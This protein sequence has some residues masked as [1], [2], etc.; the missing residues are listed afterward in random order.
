MPAPYYRLRVKSLKFISAVDA[1]AQGPVANVALIKRARGGSSVEATC[2]VIKTDERLGL[3]FG[4][5]LASSLDGGKTPHVDLQN[6]AV[7]GDDDLIKVAAEFV[8]AGARSDVLH[9]ESHDGRVVFCMPL[10]KDVNAALGIKSDVHGLAI[11]MRPSPATFKRFLSKE[12]NAFSIGGLG[13][14][15]LVHKRSARPRPVS[16]LAVLT[17]LVDG[18]QHTVDLDDPADEWRDS[19]STSY[20]TSEGADQ[21]HMHAW[22]FDPDTGAITIAAD[23]GHTHDVTEVVPDDVRTEAAV[24][25]D[26]ERCRNCNAMC[27]E[28]DRY[29]PSCGKAMNGDMPCASPVAAPASAPAVVVVA[30]RAPGADSPPRNQ[31]S[32]VNSNSQERPPM[33]PKIAKMFAAALLLPEPQRLHVAKL[34][35]GEPA[36]LQAFLSLDAA[37]REDATNA[38]LAA[39]PVVYTTKS[40][41]QIRKSHGE[42]AKSQAEQIDRQAEQIAAQETVLAVA[43][44]RNEQIEFEKRAGEAIP[45]I[46]KSL[47]VRVALLKGVSGIGDEA[48]RKEATEALVAAN[49]AFVMLSKMNGTSVEGDGVVGGDAK[50]IFNAELATFAKTLNKTPQAATGDFIR[51]DRGSELYADA[52]PR[53]L[54]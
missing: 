17:S 54:S 20:Q 32:T 22:T 48:L 21:S 44:A 28:D 19:L 42:M 5:A 9:D 41:G 3:V 16:K 46:G 10:T 49:A 37:G 24:N 11:A 30:A 14:R 6:D 25:E 7:V 35:A 53:T 34:A 36:A 40:G 23:S 52:Y 33:D 29:C 45:Q 39:D 27:D 31:P 26:G 43:K 51:T 13:Q 18:H 8:D 4:W 38:A 50:S 47:A 2:R 12:L 1:G 15:E